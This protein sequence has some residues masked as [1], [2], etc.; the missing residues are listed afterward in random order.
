MAFLFVERT[1]FLLS[2][3]G[4]HALP[5]RQLGR[6]EV[7]AASATR[8][9]GQ[10]PPGISIVFYRSSCSSGNR[11]QGTNSVP[12][13]AGSGTRAAPRQCGR[14]QMCF[15]GAVTPQLHD[16]RGCT[17]TAICARSQIFCITD[18]GC[19]VACSANNSH[20]DFK[21]DYCTVV[22]LNAALLVFILL[23]Y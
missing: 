11:D 9:Q 13:A 21:I 12:A 6:R 8:C 16:A 7:R 3:P 4:A 19:C 18:S 23:I 10:Q 2:M 14:E 20:H 15:Y 22:N 17:I 5:A 1:S